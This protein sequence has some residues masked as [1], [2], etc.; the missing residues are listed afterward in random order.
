LNRYVVTGG[1][2]PQQ[3]DDEPGATIPVDDSS[4]VGSKKQTAR[5]RRA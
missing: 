2:Y 3:H 4:H 5:R 1:K